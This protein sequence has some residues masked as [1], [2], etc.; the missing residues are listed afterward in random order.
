V[1]SPLR[2]AV[3][4][5]DAF[6]LG[7]D[8]DERWIEIDY[9]DFDGL[10]LTEVGADVWKQWRAD[11]TFAPPNGESFEQLDARVWDACA[12]LVDEASR[13]NVVVV[14]HVSPIKSAV[15]WALDVSGAIAWRMHLDVASI[16]RVAVGG[17]TPSL[18]TFNETA[19]L[20]S[21][22]A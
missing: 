7:V 12:A 18:R 10:P 4:T 11:P 5:A 14:S 15:A 9:G 3:E 16:T 17:P 19:H 8:L 21:V 22:E 13:Q 20:A 1:A 2:R 6:G